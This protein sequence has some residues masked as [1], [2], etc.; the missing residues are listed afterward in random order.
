MFKKPPILVVAL[1]LIAAAIACSSGTQTETYSEAE[2]NEELVGSGMT[3]DFQPGQI[4]LTGDVEGQALEMVLTAAAVEGAVSMEI[5]SVTVNGEPMDL[6]MFTGME[7][8]LSQMVYPDDADYVIDDIT[9][10]DT[11]ISITASRQ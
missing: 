3:A 2:F 5:V 8:E 6:A 10:T 7:A 1:A 11:E 9:I 4:V